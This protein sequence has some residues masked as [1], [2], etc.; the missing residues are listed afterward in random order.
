MLALCNCNLQPVLTRPSRHQTAS[1]TKVIV[2]SCCNALSKC[3]CLGCWCWPCIHQLFGKCCFDWKCCTATAGQSA[4]L[5]I[6]C[7]PF[8]LNCRPAS[9]AILGVFS[10]LFWK[11]EGALSFAM[12]QRGTVQSCHPPGKL[13][14]PKQEA[15]S[16][17]CSSSSTTTVSIEWYSCKCWIQYN[18]EE[19][20]A[21]RIIYA[22]MKWLSRKHDDERKGKMDMGWHPRKRPIYYFQLILFLLSFT[23]AEEK[24]GIGMALRAARVVWLSMF[25]HIFSVDAYSKI[26][27]L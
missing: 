22:R 16:L 10:F 21:T 7:C 8:W 20:I 18:A 13:C 6:C 14:L 23:W 3:Y 9:A 27:L 26:S 12:I 4:S 15:L 25:T 2:S 17:S 5:H 11:L 1:V 24:K 19:R